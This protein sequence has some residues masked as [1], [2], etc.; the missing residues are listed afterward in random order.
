[1][2]YSLTADDIPSLSA[3]IKKEA[4]QRLASFLVEMAV[5]ET[6][7]ENPSTQPSPGAVNLLKFP[8]PHAG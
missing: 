6:A 3:W 5:I 1:M 7:S 8:H 2:R 4:S